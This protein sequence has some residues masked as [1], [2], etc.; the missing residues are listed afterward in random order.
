[1]TVRPKI[2]VEG[3]QESSLIPNPILL[4]ATGICKSFGGQSVLKDV[5]F[6]LHQG[7][8]VLLRG[9]NGSGKTTLLNILTG[10]IEADKGILQYNTKEKP[11]QYSF[12]IPWWKSLNALH[13]FSPEFVANK[14]ITRT[15]QDIRLFNSLSLKDNVTV[16][17]S[18]RTGE[19]P[20]LAL[21]SFRKAKKQEREAAKNAAGL[22]ESFDLGSLLKNK[23]GKISLGQ[24]KRVAIARAVATG[25]DI[26]LMD[27]P[28]SGL[29]L[30]G[31]SSMIDFLKKLA[32]DKNMTI[33][34]IEHFLN[35]P[36]IST[37]ATTNW[38]LENGKLLITPAVSSDYKSIINTSVTKNAGNQ[39][40][41]LVPEGTDVRVEALPNDDALT[42]IRY[43][44][45]D[46]SKADVVLEIKELQVKR[47]SHIIEWKNS[48]TSL[49]LSL[50]VYRGEVILFQAANGWGK[51]T[52]LD[53]LTGEIPK[54]SGEI[55]FLGEY[56]DET[57][58][59]YKRIR[60]GMQVIPASNNL[61]TNLSGNEML[62]LAEAT[63]K[64][65]GVAPL[66][67]R[68][69]NQLSGGQKQRIALATVQNT[70]NKQLVLYDEPLSGLDFKSVD[71]FEHLFRPDPSCAKVIFLPSSSK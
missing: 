12:P 37:L 33:V 41:F 64:I 69:I 29:D 15:W 5:N 14:G 23:A 68:P 67:E 16:A 63:N 71:L 60:N 51:T 4:K 20:F 18:N 34:I 35:I 49:G 28:F 53:T 39:F 40:D 31:I 19:N 8:I 24:S 26:L 3:S 46:E 47:E 10:N 44:G 21:V 6:Q 17:Y 22:L 38:H 43:H 30:K 27:E 2:S 52:L 42:R 7:E 48:D 32:H 58:T 25:A 9:E 62:K 59:S 70:R 65:Q 50:K 55:I 1:M 54:L 11:F 61:F 45:Y 56:L 66:L 13:N 36:L 57:Y